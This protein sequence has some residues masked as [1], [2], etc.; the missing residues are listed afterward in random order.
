VARGVFGTGQEVGIEERS[1]V[2]ALLWMTANGGLIA[3]GQLS[4]K[5][6]VMWREFAAA[7]RADRVGSGV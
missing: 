6:I 5:R 2:A 7:L 4:K 3:I 1:F